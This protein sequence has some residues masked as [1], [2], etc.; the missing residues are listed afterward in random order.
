MIARVVLFR[1]QA[2]KAT[3]THKVEHSDQA[4]SQHLERV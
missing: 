1:E 4:Q 2:K 3:K